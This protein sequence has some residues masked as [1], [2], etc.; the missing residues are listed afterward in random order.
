M[1]FRSKK[2]DS[3][4]LIE[5]LLTYG[6]NRTILRK[7]QRFFVSIPNRVFD[8][9]KDNLREVHGIWCQDADTLYDKDLGFVGFD[10]DTTM[11]Y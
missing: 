9:V 4:D 10:N 8:E 2:V 3:L 6:P 5:Q 11:S 7:L 1:L